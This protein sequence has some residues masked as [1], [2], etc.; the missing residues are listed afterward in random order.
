VCVCVCVCVCVGVCVCVSVCVSVCVRLS[1]SLPLSV[2]VGVSV[3][4][5]LSLSVC[6]CVSVF[7]CVRLQAAF[8]TN[9]NDLFASG[10]AN[11]APFFLKVADPPWGGG[12][13]GVWPLPP[14][15][16]PSGLT[17]LGS[18][19]PRPRVSARPPT[20][21]GGLKISLVPTPSSTP[22]PPPRFAPLPF[23]PPRPFT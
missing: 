10:D 20:G 18:R 8:D 2:C 1:L 7:V 15:N 19:D 22:A 16:P 6:V 12:A 21:G 17:H 3:C 5:R 23:R 4:A 14:E 9:P 13:G 11:Q